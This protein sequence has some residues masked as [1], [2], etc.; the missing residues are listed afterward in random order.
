MK[1]RISKTLY[2]NSYLVFKKKM[3]VFTIVLV[4][5]G[6]S[7]FEIIN[8]VDN[9]IINADILSTMQQKS[10]K[11]FLFMGMFFAVFVVRGLL[12]LLIIWVSNPSVGLTGA[13]T[14]TFSNNT[15]VM[16]S[17]E[18]SA[19]ILLVG[20]AT[21]LL[22]LFF[23]WLFIEP[24]KYI[25]SA[26][27]FFQAN[28]FLFY[29]FVSIL[30]SAIVWFAIHRNP[31]M[32]FSAVIGATIFYVVEAIRRFAEEHASRLNKKNISDV[33]KILYLEVIDATFS[34]DGVTGAFAFTLSVPFILVGNG[35]GALVVRQLT[36]KNVNV[37]NKFKYLKKGAMYSILFIGFIM[38]LDSF[39]YII[40]KWL[41]PL[42]TFAVVG[43]FLYMSE[44]DLAQGPRRK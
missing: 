8:S 14:A 2:T 43:F 11:W 21:F 32:A 40:P 5:A 17:I 23:H 28:F 7:V 6:L 18:S 27:K 38:L 41:P 22:F 16:Q 3:D 44:R 13:F 20:A 25:L 29:A 15:A 35:I 19:P 26:E 24:K 36:I 34:I 9:A 30:L 33:G 42:V 12:P 37:I 10:R 1:P 31:L 4:I 39:G